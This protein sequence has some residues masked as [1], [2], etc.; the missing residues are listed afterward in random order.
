MFNRD[1][2]SAG[3]NDYTIAARIWPEPDHEAVKNF[4][5]CS[6]KGTEADWW[7]PN[8]LSCA[9]AIFLGP[10][11]LWSFFSLPGIIK[12]RSNE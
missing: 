8:G 3:V 5:S 7:H 1:Q 10:F 6:V 4:Q 9:F 12:T 2:T 11:A